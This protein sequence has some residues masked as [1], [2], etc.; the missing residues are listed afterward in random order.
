MSIWAH[1]ENARLLLNQFRRKN[2]ALTTYFHV[3]FHE[4][5]I[6]ASDAKWI[7]NLN[8]CGYSRRI[9]DYTLY[10]AILTPIIHVFPNV[11]ISYPRDRIWC[12]KRFFTTLPV[13]E[14]KV[15]CDILENIYESP[16]VGP[17]I[18]C[19]FGHKK[20]LLDPPSDSIS[21]IY[22]WRQVNCYHDLPWRNANSIDMK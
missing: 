12:I 15:D 9:V 3:L 4:W 21:G 11:V 19:R 2:A 17:L 5:W 20:I 18:S 14:W 1:S 16:C 10:F 13:S 8:Y 7:H 6:Q 22:V